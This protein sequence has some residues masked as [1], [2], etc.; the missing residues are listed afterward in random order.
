M[1]VESTAVVKEGLRPVQITIIITLL[2]QQQ[3]QQLNKQNGEDLKQ[4]FSE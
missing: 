1:A 4:S 3:R 2:Q